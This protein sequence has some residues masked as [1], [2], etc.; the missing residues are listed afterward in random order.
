MKH[1]IPWSI[2]CALAAWEPAGT[3]EAPEPF[4]IVTGGGKARLA[5]DRYRLDFMV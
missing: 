1:T 2:T 3:Q 5:T 4:L